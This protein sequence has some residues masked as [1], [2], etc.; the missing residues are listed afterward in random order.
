MN[1]RFARS[2]KTI[3]HVEIGTSSSRFL[4]IPMGISSSSYPSKNQL[5]PRA[6]SLKRIAE[7]VYPRPLDYPKRA[8]EHQRQSP[9]SAEPAPE[10]AHP[11]VTA[12][13]TLGEAHVV[14]P[15]PKPHIS[16]P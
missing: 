1:T 6:R 8:G 2:R 12:P 4:V 9:A 10:S 15:S 14:Y 5:H 13:P 7:V 3:A 16:G 11:L